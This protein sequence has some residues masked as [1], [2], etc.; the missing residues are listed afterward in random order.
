MRLSGLTF[1]AT[2]DLAFAFSRSFWVRVDDSYVIFLG[3]V[4]L[5]FCLYMFGLHF[6]FVQRLNDI[7]QNLGG[8]KI[9]RELNLATLAPIAKPPN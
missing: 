8:Y 5:S 1:D 4:G 2:L 7:Q 9:W 6:A 3:S